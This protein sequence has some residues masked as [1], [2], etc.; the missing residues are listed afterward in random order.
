MVNGGGSVLLEFSRSDLKT[1]QIPTIAMWNQFVNMDTIRMFLADDISHDLDLDIS[2]CPANT[3]D[4]TNVR[5]IVKTSWKEVR[6]HYYKN[7][8]ILPDS[9][10]VRNELDLMETGLKLV[11]TSNQASGFSSTIFIVLTKS[12]IPE[13]LKLIHLKIAVEG[14]LHTQT[15]DANPSQSYEYSWDRRNAYEQRVYGVTYAKV[16]VGYEYEDCEYIYWQTSGVKLAGYD[17]GSSEIGSWNI[18]VH[19]RLN[20]QQGILHKGDGTT[21]YLNYIQTQIEIAAGQLNKKRNIDCNV[22]E[23]CDRYS[24]EPIKFYSPSSMTISKDGLMF[25]VDHN[26]VWLLNNTGVPERILELK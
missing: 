8:L 12:T 5:P 18:D 20:P 11:Y 4:S 24:N 23:Q 9:G 19:H 1:K 22:G 13:S 6:T 16:M 21:I 26:Y 7:S 14:V 3:H 25:I 17:L 15:L 2:H 10:A